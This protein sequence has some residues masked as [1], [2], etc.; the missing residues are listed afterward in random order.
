M[1]EIALGWTAFWMSAPF[2]MFLVAMVIFSRWVMR[3]TITES[4]AD[5]FISFA[6]DVAKIEATLPKMPGAVL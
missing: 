2:A 3:R 5:E 6:S 4:F 1:D